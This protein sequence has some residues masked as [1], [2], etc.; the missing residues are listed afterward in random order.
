MF[1]QSRI[2]GITGLLLLAFLFSAAAGLGPDRAEKI[3]LASSISISIC[4][5]FFRELSVFA[6]PL[7]ALSKDL[8][9]S[10]LT[11]DEGQLY[12]SLEAPRL[13]IYCLI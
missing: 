10:S 6:L 3:S 13:G 8:E 12:N 4:L 9:E 2:S 11:S 5:L 1:Q 7:S